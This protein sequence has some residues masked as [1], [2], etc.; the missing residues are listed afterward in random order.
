MVHGLTS[1][2]VEA[3]NTGFLDDL[4]SG[5]GQFL[6]DGSLRMRYCSVKFSR[7]KPTWWGCRI[8]VAWLFWFLPL[9][10]I[11]R[12]LV[13]RVLVL[14][15]TLETLTMVEEGRYDL[16]KR[17]MCVNVLESILG[18]SQFPNVGGLTL[19]GIG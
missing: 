1:R 2:P 15:P 13:C 7:K 3:T 18:G 4:L 9:I 17:L 16:P 14:S 6:V 11:R 10:L 8:L 19:S 5:S 12:L